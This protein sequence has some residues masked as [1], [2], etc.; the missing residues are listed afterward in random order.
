MKN[1]MDLIKKKYEYI[2]P[3][4]HF[5]L[6][7]L[8]QGFI[9]VGMGSWEQYK[10]VV[11][12]DNVLSD[13]AEL[14][15]VYVL[16]RVFSLLIILG[17]WRL[18]F[19]VTK[20]NVSRNDCFI[21]GS[22][23][24]IGLLF[25]IVCYPT[26][27]KIEIDNYT[28]FFM[29]RRFQPTYWNG[30]YTGA[31]YAGCFMIFPHP[32]TLNIFQWVFFWFAVSYIYLGIG[33]LYGNI[34]WKYLILLLFV[35]PEAFFLTFD[36]YR[37][38][39]YTI[40]LLVYISYI[41][42]CIKR[43]ELDFSFKNMV[44]FSLFT[45]FIMVWRS[46]GMLFGVGGFFI[47]LM[48]VVKAKYTKNSKAILWYLIS[49]SIMFLVLNQI[50]A[51]GSKKYY[52]KDYMI[53]NTT[54]VLYSIF[55]STNSNLTYEGVEEDLSAIDAVVPVQVLKENGMKGYRNYNWNEGRKDFN[56]TSA[57]YE[58]ASSYMSAY[59]RLIANNL[60]IYFKGQ[61]DSFL[62]AL[63][64]PG[65]Y[66]VYSNRDNQGLDNFVYDEWQL[67]YVEV[68]EMWNTYSWENNYFRLL[69][70]SNILDGFSGWKDWLVKT[71]ISAIMHILSIV[72]IVLLFL[73]ELISVICKKRKLNDALPFVISFIVLLGE[74]LAIVLF[75]PESRKAYFYPVLFGNYLLIY[76]YIVVRL[77]ERYVNY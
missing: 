58:Q 4:A 33:E 65:S 24:V 54:N 69:L 36:A 66:V 31:L 32:I 43:A 1:T 16:S 19:Y 10:S 59:Y 60:G 3:L 41:F 63:Q 67:G 64:V 8:W 7:F 56:Q 40:L 44:L 17:L 20:K 52:G 28:N 71:G 49:L 9:F 22:I 75:M 13:R 14:L 76:L 53:I 12:N 39:F 50:Q 70:T 34:I 15:L 72:T 42:F 46:E 62:T 48:F 73:K 77:K 37:N 38:N 29:A 18:F 2:I 51:V 5:L 23:L 61:I 74:C 26:F 27:W 11:I 57:T 25:V 35:L 30:I 55:N 68:R 45:A 47:Y 6:S 21:L